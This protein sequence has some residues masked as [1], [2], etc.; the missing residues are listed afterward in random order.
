MQTNITIFYTPHKIIPASLRMAKIFL[1]Y[2]RAEGCGNSR[3]SCCSNIPLLR[4][5]G[6][7]PDGSGITDI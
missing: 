1:P 4:L 7:R 5:M 3:K 6:E 2:P